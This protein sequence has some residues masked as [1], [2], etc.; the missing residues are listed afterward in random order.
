MTIKATA[1]PGSSGKMRLRLEEDGKL[2]YLEFPIPLAGMIAMVLL[3]GARTASERAGTSL[4]GVGG[5]QP[6]KIGLAQGPQE[7]CLSLVLHA[8]RTRLA[9]QM[10]AAQIRDLQRTLQ[11]LSA[12]E[13]RPQ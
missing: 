6:S 7:G 9:V 10:E 11:T 3:A 12:P 13:D 4:E 5:F 1:G 8:G 2:S